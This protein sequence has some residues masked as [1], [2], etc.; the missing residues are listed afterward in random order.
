MNRERLLRAYE[1]IDGIP[2][3]KFNLNDFVIQTGKGSLKCGT[4]ACAAGWISLH[5][6]FSPLLNPEQHMTNTGMAKWSRQQFNIVD[7]LGVLR[8][9]SSYFNAMAYLFNL[10]DLE[11]LHL[12]G[13][14]ADYEIGS[15][16]KEMWQ[17]R[18]KS[19]LSLT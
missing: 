2:D 10:S 6:E 1:I 15:N 8:K 3:S 13:M 17:N 19:L 16:H 14:P 12:F 11:S 4:I 7:R 5:P 18:V 9:T